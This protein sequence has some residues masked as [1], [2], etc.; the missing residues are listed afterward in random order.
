MRWVFVLLGLLLLT[1]CGST[2]GTPVASNGT[3]I[4]VYRSAS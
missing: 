1:A 3:T 2:G 4:E